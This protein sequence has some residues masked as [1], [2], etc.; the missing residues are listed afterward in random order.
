MN[1]T[2]SAG[3]DGTLLDAYSAAVVGAVEQA[4]PCVVNIETAQRQLGRTTSGRGSGSAEPPRGGGSG[5]LFTPDGFIL[6][7]S[8]VV[9]GAAGIEV[10]HADGG[11]FGAQLVGDDPDTDLAVLRIIGADLFYAGLGD[12]SAIRVGQLAVAIGNPHGFQFTVTAGVV[13]A[14]GRSLRSRSGRLI[15]NVIQTDAALNPGSSGGPLVN[16]RGEVIGVN[17][18]MIF[19]AQG[20]CF[21]IA[22]NTATLVAGFLMRDGAVRRSRLGIGAQDTRLP[23]S[24]VRYYSLPVESGVRI[25]SVEP[26]GP[27]LQADIFSGDIIVSY[28]GQP[29]SGIDDLQRLLTGQQVGVRAPIAVIRGNRKLD[30]EIVAEESGRSRR[31][32][33]PTAS[34]VGGG[35]AGARPPA[36]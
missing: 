20:I 36:E 28:N 29:V 7:N 33:A 6:T 24:L 2:P 30:L 9:H 4:G 32:R 21:A 31:T 5:F 3:S 15:D 25:M 17:S 27:A 16:W 11:K 12:S 22:S 13:S 26:A 19:G 18:A 8:H 14:L 35:G 1:D 10:T 23:R 34:S